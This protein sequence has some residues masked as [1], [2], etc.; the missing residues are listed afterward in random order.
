MSDGG[1]W[2]PETTEPT[3]RARRRDDGGDSIRHS[4]YRFRA[5]ATNARA[6]PPARRATRCLLLEHAKLGEAPSV[7]PTGPPCSRSRG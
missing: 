5:V 4:A 1:A 2:L 7:T 3:S 6:A